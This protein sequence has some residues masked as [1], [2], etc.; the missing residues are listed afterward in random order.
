ME[1]HGWCKLEICTC[2]AIGLNWVFI[3]VI[4]KNPWLL[5]F[6]ILSCMV[7][8]N[9]NANQVPFAQYKPYCGSGFKEVFCLGAADALM[10]EFNF[11]ITFIVLSVTTRYWNQN[12]RWLNIWPY[13]YYSY[14]TYNTTPWIASTSVQYT[15]IGH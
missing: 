6:L 9:S 10:P 8:T 2:R 12:K 11:L 4:V 7:L 13:D 1:I 5:Y 15:G 3:H 14:N